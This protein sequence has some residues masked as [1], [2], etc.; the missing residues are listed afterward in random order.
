[1]SGIYDRGDD[2]YAR[3]LATAI[4]DENIVVMNFILENGGRSMRP[5]RG[6]RVRAGPR[7]RVRFYHI[8]APPEAPW[9]SGESRR[10]F[11]YRKAGLGL[12][13]VLARAAGGPRDR[14]HRDLHDR[15]RRALEGKARRRT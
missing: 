11:I 2:N 10:L 7:I 15:R 4:A 3:A 9:C 14:T 13:G 1:M 8:R 6:L 12:P 5:A